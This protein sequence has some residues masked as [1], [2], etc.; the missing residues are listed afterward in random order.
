MMAS[1]SGSLISMVVPL[2]SRESIWITPFSCAMRVFTTS[3]PTPRP[4]TS[5]ISVLV[6][7]PAAK[8]S[9]KHSRSESRAAASASIMPFSTALARSLSG[10]MPAPSSLM[11]RRM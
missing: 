2:P 1:V 5:E 6:E 7:K 11:V 10:S 3:M 4:E 8:M 9:S